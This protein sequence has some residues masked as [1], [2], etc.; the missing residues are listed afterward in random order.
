MRATGAASTPPD[1]I[2]FATA[3]C[4]LQFDTP[5]SG[6]D[7]LS[8]FSNVS[9]FALPVW[10]PRHHRY[11]PATEYSGASECRSEHILSTT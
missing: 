11:S 7:G 3:T 8:Q 1:P 10:F 5:N 2:Y 6:S 9:M 4:L